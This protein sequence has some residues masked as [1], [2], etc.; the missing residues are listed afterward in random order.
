[1]PHLY[2]RSLSCL[3]WCVRPSI[4]VVSSVGLRI[5]AI[6]SRGLYFTSFQNISTQRP[7]PSTKT[8]HL[9]K[10]KEGYGGDYHL[11]HQYNVAIVLHLCTQLWSGLIAL[12]PE[13][14]VRRIDL[15]PLIVRKRLEHSFQ[16]N[17]VR[18][19]SNEC[20]FLMAILRWYTHHFIS[21][22]PIIL[23]A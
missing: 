8:W 15:L 9:L 23:V 1:M 5:I 19:K 14:S 4:L 7:A 13:T 22:R 18:V 11:I 10:I 2:L 12:W 3:H 16:T 21:K 17:A 20:N 6:V